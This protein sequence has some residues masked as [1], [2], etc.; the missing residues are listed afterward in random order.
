[1]LE[2]YL[3]DHTAG[4]DTVVDADRS[5]V[6]RVVSSPQVVLVTCVVGPLVD[7]EA[8]ALHPDGVASVEVG[9][10]VG[11]VTAALVGAPLEV[12]VFV[13]YDL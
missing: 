6:I 7:H 13:E 2:T 12:L 11:A 9:M 8:A 4:P 1:M 10:E 5:L 3:G